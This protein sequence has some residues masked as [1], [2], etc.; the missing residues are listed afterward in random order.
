LISLLIGF[1]IG[2]LLKH[3]LKFAV[4]VIIVVVVLLTL[5]YATGSAFD[6]VLSLISPEVKQI[7]LDS[8]VTT[9]SGVASSVLF[10]FGLALAVWRT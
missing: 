8:Q 5:G 6:E 4:I 3:F 1:I 7:W 2:A 10:F 9:A